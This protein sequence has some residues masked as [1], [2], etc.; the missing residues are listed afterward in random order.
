M[1]FSRGAMERFTRQLDCNN[2]IDTADEYLNLVCAQLYRNVIREKR[3]WENNS[4]LTDLIERISNRFF[5][6][7][8]SDHLVGHFVN[9]YLFAVAWEEEENFNSIEYVP[10]IHPY[11][12]SFKTLDRP[13]PMKR[14]DLSNSSCLVAET[15]EECLPTTPV[16]HYVNPETMKRVSSQW[17]R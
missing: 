9:Y 5:N 2:A 10:R 1:I 12:G 16:C 17:M 15:N 11:Q 3:S 8:I 4:S 7:F 6:C 13:I 14:A